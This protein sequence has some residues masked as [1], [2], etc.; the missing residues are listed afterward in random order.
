M[1]Q[2]TKLHNE[3]KLLFALFCISA[4]TALLLWLPKPTANAKFEDVL[5][6]HVIAASNSEEDQTVKYRLADAIL[7]QITALTA[8]CQSVDEARNVLLQHQDNIQSSASLILENMGYNKGVLVEIGEF[9]YD[10]RNLNGK[11]YPAG[12][13]PSLRLV[14]GEGEGQNCWS[15]LFPTTALYISSDGGTEILTNPTYSFSRD[16]V[17]LRFKSV[18]WLLALLKTN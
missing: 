8:A 11:I 14:I 10:R 18:D 6:L 4:L 13:Y 16:N 2:N 15:V 5:R 17:S 7:P 1:N 9:R 3:K 12:N